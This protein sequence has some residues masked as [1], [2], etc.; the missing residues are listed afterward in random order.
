MEKEN[1]KRFL[2]LK[3]LIEKKSYFLMGLRQTGKSTLIE[4]QLSEIR[5]YDLL[6]KED[7]KK[8]SFNPSLIKE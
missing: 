6:L 1:I 7:F 3:K 5:R 4:A 2:D 8:L